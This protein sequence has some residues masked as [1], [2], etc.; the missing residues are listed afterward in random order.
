MKH[1]VNSQADRERLKLEL[2]GVFNQLKLGEVP[3]GIQISVPNDSRSCV[4]SLNDGIYT[5]K[6]PWYV[7][8]YKKIDEAIVEVLECLVSRELYDNNFNTSEINFV[9]SKLIK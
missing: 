2:S 7:S 8:T 6:S 5:V 1:S 3:D 9:V 4:V